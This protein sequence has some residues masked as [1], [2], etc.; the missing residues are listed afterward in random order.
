MEGCSPDISSERRATYLARR[1]A[2]LETCRAALKSGQINIIREIAHKL[3]GNCDT[4]GFPEWTDI[5]VKLEKA[6][7]TENKQAI[8]AEF[9]RLE[10]SILQLP[11]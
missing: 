3:K 5:A 9:H 11:A 10:E 4:F 2:E 7:V 8:F 6:C 1:R